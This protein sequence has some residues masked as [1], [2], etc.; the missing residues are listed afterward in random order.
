M[1]ARADVSAVRAQRSDPLEDHL[2]EE[3]D[4]RARDVVRVGEERTVA[5]V[6]PLLRLDP[7]DGEDHVVGLAREEVPA[8]RAAVAQQSVPR[9][10]PLDLLAVAGAEHVIKH[11]ALLLDP[12]ERGDVLVR[13]EQDP[14][15]ARSRLRGEIGLP[16]DEAVR[17][18]GE[19]ARHVR[20]VPVS[21]RALEHGP[22]EAVD[23]EVDDAGHVRL[24]ALAGAP[25][26][27]LDHADR[28]RVVVVR[29]G[30]DLEHG[31]DR[32]DHERGDERRPESVDGDLVADGRRP[33]AAAPA[34]R[35]RRRRNDVATVYGSRSG[36][37]ER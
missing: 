6:R 28:V 4:E 3:E 35:A 9:V 34:S 16:L 19:P 36:G 20:R 37:D 30:D 31:R 22:R 23:L 15:L 17:V 25:R 32:R 10:P 13:A 33:Q 2:P 7:A 12:A 11:A 14:R 21:H 5:G 8:A 18:L 29:A 24:D 27:P 1:T 26:D